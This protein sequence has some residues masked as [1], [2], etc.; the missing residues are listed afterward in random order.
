MAA[1]PESGGEEEETVRSQSSPAPPRLELP[2]AGRSMEVGAPS[3]SHRL[4]G[5]RRGR[6]RRRRQWRKRIWWLARERGE[7]RRGGGKWGGGRR[8]RGGAPTDWGMVGS[9]AR[10]SG[11]AA[12]SLRL[13]LGF[14]SGKGGVAACFHVSGCSVVV[15]GHRATSGQP[16]SYCAGP[17][18]WAESAAQ[19]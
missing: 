7:R 2:H 15:L 17:T 12:A 4:T 8:Q 18:R 3:P 11:C 13:R 5:E 19:H 16:V 9:G 1:T 10:G 6:R 14:E